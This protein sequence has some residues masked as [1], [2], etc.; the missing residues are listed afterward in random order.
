M[1]SH[2]PLE[3]FFT[4]NLILCMLVVINIFF[5]PMVRATDSGLACP[6][7]P[8]CHG[9]VI[10]PPDFKNWMEVGHRIYSG[11][12]SL[13]LLAMMIW[14]A[15]VEI[16]RKNFFKPYILSFV[17]IVNQV[18]L[19]M[20]TVTKLLDPTTVNLHYLNAIFLLAI[21]ATI[22]LKAQYLVAN[23]EEKK[24]SLSSV[25]QKKTIVL[26]L[27]LIVIFFQLFLGGRVSSHYAGLACPDFPTCNGFFF[28]ETEGV[29]KY[30]M[31]HRFGAYAV[32]LFLG[33]SF[34]LSK[35]FSFEKR[36]QFFLKSALHAAVL[37][38]GLGA[39]NV[40]FQL[41]VLVT[42]MHSAIGAVVFILA[43][44]ALYRQILCYG[45]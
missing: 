4:L 25:F 2:S 39:T 13:I 31:E 10:P 40:L 16:L 3:K 17:I 27:T 22:A 35:K 41:P 37:Q 24:I 32:I 36:S 9:K 43:Y 30:Q 34:L 45:T 1:K 28:P 19:G 5:G 15:R 11:I 21:F 18:V 29:V 20:L 7:W 38:I 23:S 33:I 44:C 8:L 6:D 14:T 12:I 42:A 26:Y